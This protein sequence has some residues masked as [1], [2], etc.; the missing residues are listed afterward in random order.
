MF[1]TTKTTNNQINPV[2]IL[3]RFPL[4]VGAT[5]SLTSAATTTLDSEAK[6]MSDIWPRRLL[7]VAAAWNILG[8]ASALFDPE[9]HFAQL[10]TASLSL[11]DP[12]QLFF[13]RC[14]WI[15]VIAWGVGYSLA[16]FLPGARVPVLAA[17]AAGK[18]FYFAACWSAFAGGVGKPALLVAGVADLLFVGLFAFILVAQWRSSLHKDAPASFSFPR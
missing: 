5:P 8:S 3:P 17:G 13:F 11:N 4:I 10:F 1:E 12:L 2:K 14:T 18:L 7:L 15:N 16:A 9:K 6:T